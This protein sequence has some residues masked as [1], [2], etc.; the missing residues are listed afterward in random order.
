MGEERRGRSFTA[1][2]DKV[3]TPLDFSQCNLCPVIFLKSAPRSLAC[4]RCLITVEPLNDERFKM[5]SASHLL[6]ERHQ[7]FFLRSEVPSFWDCQDL[8][9]QELSEIF[10]ERLLIIQ[11]KQGK[12]PRRIVE[13]HRGTTL[14]LWS[15]VQAAWHQKL[16]LTALHILYRA[17]KC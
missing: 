3:F 15:G 4:S 11:I 17:L 10:L 8:P 7:H 9:S 12:L 13:E 14:R 16:P 2:Q 6:N 1:G 5:S